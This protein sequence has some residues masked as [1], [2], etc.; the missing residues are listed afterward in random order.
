VPGTRNL[1]V[2]AKAS[3]RRFTFAV[4]FLVREGKL[5]EVAGQSFFVRRNASMRAMGSYIDPCGEGAGFASL[6]LLVLH[7]LG[8]AAMVGLREL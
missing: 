3:E 2:K 7:E 5:E 1:T 6:S 8:T 4:C